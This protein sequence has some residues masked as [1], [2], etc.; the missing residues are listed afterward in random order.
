VDHIA[1]DGLLGR[2]LGGSFPSGPASKPM[3][4]IWKMVVENRIAAYNV[5]SGVLFDMNRETAAKRPGVLTKVGMDTFVDP[6][7]EG[8]AMNDLAA[9]DPI[10]KPG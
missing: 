5:P 4:E 1:K 2:I 8:C 3:P 7:R 10:S 9:A 6:I